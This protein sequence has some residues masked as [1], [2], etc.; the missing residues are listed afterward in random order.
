M[1]HLCDR[2]R[3]AE[4]IYLPANWN[5]VA[6]RSTSGDSK[7]YE[8]KRCT[9]VIRKLE[10]Y[11]EDDIVSGKLPVGYIEEKWIFQCMQFIGISM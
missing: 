9:G 3:G 11:S 5:C 10:E 7:Y 2:G 6:D 4:R 8:W 1:Y